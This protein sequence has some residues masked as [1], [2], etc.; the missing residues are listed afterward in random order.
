MGFVPSNVSTRRRRDSSTYVITIPSHHR[1]PVL[2]SCFPYFRIQQR[3]LKELHDSQLKAYT[4]AAQKSLSDLAKKVPLPHVE[5]GIDE[6]MYVERVLRT[7]EIPEWK[8][9]RQF[10]RIIVHKRASQHYKQ[11]VAATVAVSSSNH[12]S[13]D[14]DE[15]MIAEIVEDV[16]DG[17]AVGTDDDDEEEGELVETEDT[18]PGPKKF[19][20]KSARINVS[21]QIKKK[22]AP[23]KI[24]R[25]PLRGRK[26]SNRGRGRG[27]G[28]RGQAR[29]A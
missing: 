7:L 19:V 11:H 18:P 15:G 5:P 10:V 28:A 1:L 12:N 29:P 22:G 8:V 4:S 20:S 26:P 3:R 27:S 6:S 9:N 24:P 25:A 13:D 14:D 16:D 2:Y 17:N 23:S 21:K